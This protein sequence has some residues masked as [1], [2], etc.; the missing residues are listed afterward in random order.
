MRRLRTL[1]STEE[2][3]TKKKE[4][5]GEFFVQR[6][7]PEDIVEGAK[8]KASTLTQTELLQPRHQ[9]NE[10]QKVPF[11]TTYHPAVNR[12]FK[13]LKGNWNILEQDFPDSNIFKEGPVL[14]MRRGKSL[15]DLLVHSKESEMN[16]IGGTFPCNRPK[17]YTCPFTNKQPIVQ[18]EDGSWQV[19]QRHTCTSISNVRYKMLKCG[20][21]YIGKTKRRLGDRYRNFEGTFSKIYNITSGH[22]LHKS[23]AQYSR[24]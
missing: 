20:K 3:F 11:V 18:G 2:D 23:T 9:S 22:A 4:Q 16:E 24:C 8:E 7:Y 21:L 6:G 15:R 1:I 17:C 19:K 10:S 13:V 12:I 5:M 14:S